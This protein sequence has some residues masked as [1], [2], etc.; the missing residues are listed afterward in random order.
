[1]RTSKCVPEDYVCAC[2]GVCVIGDSWNKVNVI[3]LTIWKPDRGSTVCSH[4]AQHLLFSLLFVHVCVCVSVGGVRVC[5]FFDHFF[6]DK[7]GPPGLLFSTKTLT[8]SDRTASGVLLGGDLLC[9]GDLR[10]CLI[11]DNNRKKDLR[12]TEFFLFS[13][14]ILVLSFLSPLWLSVSHFL[15]LFF[16]TF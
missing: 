10:V 12:R 3:V 13:E 8:W 15:S 7:C 4:F 2:V 11:V 1:M 9:G 14:S 6:H 5:V 16:H